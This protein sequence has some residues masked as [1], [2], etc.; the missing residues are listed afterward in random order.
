MLMSVS[1]RNYRLDT[2]SQYQ[3]SVHTTATTT[4]T[5]TTTTTATT[6]TTT[7]CS[8]S[9]VAMTSSGQVK[10]RLTAGDASVKKRC[11]VDNTTVS[12]SRL[13]HYIVILAQLYNSPHWS[14]AI[15]LAYEQ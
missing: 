5:S 8:G 7:S 14:R 10:R 1:S 9:G 11:H 12:V 15:S 3:R 6:T 13:R 4:T 2:F